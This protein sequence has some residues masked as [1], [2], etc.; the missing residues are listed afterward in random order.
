MKDNAYPIDVYSVYEYGLK[1]WQKDFFWPMDHNW[2]L[3]VQKDV[4]NLFVNF[5]NENDNDIGDIVLIKSKIYYELANILY[6]IKLV[7][8]LKRLGRRI[9]YSDKSF[10][11]KGLIERGIPEYTFIENYESKPIPVLR[12]L[13]T[14]IA[15]LR[16]NIA[17]RLYFAL[18]KDEMPIV[19]T[20]RSILNR[21]YFKQLP[22]RPV[23]LF[24]CGTIFK[25]KTTLSDDILRSLK[26][27]IA[28]FTGKMCEI[29]DRYSVPLSQAQKAFMR[30]YMTRQFNKAAEDYIGIKET[31]RDLRKFHVIS[32]SHGSY[33]ARL[34]G[35]AAK[36]VGG[37]AT[38]FSHGY[39]VFTCL[40][41]IHS[42]ED[43][44]TTDEYV[45]QLESSVPRINKVIQKYPIP[46]N[47]RVE[48]VPEECTSL[49]DLYRRKKGMKL[50]ENI[51]TVMVMGFSYIIDF[52]RSDQL[53]DLVY[54]DYETRLID[55]L[56][57][58][59]YK[60]LYKKHPDGMLK[61]DILKIFGEK[62]TVIHDRF[63]D[64][65]DEG[66]A[67]LFSAAGSSTWSPAVCT[68]KP[69][70]YINNNWHDIW[71]PEV[72]ELVKKRCRVVSGWFDERNRYIF[73]EKELLDVLSQKVEPPNTEFLEACMFPKK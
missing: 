16:D 6:A 40:R 9:V 59:G 72:Y 70:I 71:F 3:E 57:D 46:R 28:L 42:I 23:C 21:K 52:V 64:V 10:Y 44:S 33:L 54:L 30:D 73:N 50:P 19:V 43:W 2:F 45:I 17:C 4:R 67:F 20:R 15:R 38:N 7:D 49:Q 24:D 14:K 29:A 56:A 51:K 37:K 27:T 11:F 55:F 48:F 47:N 39:D 69:I 32:G 63:E 36:R 41:K 25:R 58:R 65:M 31:L 35:L 5:A 13:M 34:L 26:N 66:D 62:A 12:Q 18:S 1:K 61:G 68:Q 22:R 8:E 53:P 60:I